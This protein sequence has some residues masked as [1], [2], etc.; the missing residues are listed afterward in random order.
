MITLKIV[1]AFVKKYW[2]LFLA[3]A[4]FI[5]FKLV[6]RQETR[7]ISEVISD[8]QK[9]HEEELRSIKEAET[10]RTQVLEENA[11]RL[12]ARLN[13]IEQQYKVAQAVLDDKKRD[14]L[15]TILKESQDD[16][17]ELARRLSEASGFK[18]YVQ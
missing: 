3:I 5:I 18:I 17:D 13:E 2:W 6:F 8:I 11:L 14:Q 9:K 4:G 10:R 15:N 12:Q 1:F 7:D 16:P